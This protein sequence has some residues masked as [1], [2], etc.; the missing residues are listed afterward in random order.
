MICYRLYG[1]VMLTDRLARTADGVVLANL[2]RLDKHL[3]INND[4]SF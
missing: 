2:E 4:N 1:V 3:V